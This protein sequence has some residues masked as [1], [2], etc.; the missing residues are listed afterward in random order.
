MHLVQILLPLADNQGRSFPEALY[1]QVRQELLQRFGGLTAYARAPA[2]GLWQ[3]TGGGVD[4]DDV[5]V[6]EVM[7]DRLDRPWW[8]AYCKEL[9]QR[10]RQQELIARAQVI[11]RL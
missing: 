4:S 1:S 7:V 11:E 6:V 5:M 8:G 2:R 10:F 3:D 9:A